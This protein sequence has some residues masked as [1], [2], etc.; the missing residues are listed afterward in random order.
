MAGVGRRRRVIGFGVASCVA[1]RGGVRL[2][3]YV[4]SQGAMAST[5]FEASGAGSCTNY[6]AA[7]DE[8]G[9]QL[10]LF[11]RHGNLV[12]P[13]PRGGCDHPG[14]APSRCWQS[15]RFGSG[16]L[17][18]VRGAVGCEVHG[19]GPLLR[20]AAITVRPPLPYRAMAYA[21]PISAWCA[22]GYLPA[23][24]AARLPDRQRIELGG[25]LHRSGQ[26]ELK[27]RTE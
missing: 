15:R 16:R 3:N 25:P 19:G 23:Q 9:R 6:L 17:G 10:A 20:F 1:R 2:A 13:V 4:E 26:F 7:L 11:D 22:F 12:C 24:R 18:L 5:L 21:I 8:R 27:T 14:Q